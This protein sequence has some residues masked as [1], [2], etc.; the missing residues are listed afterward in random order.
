MALRLLHIIFAIAVSAGIYSTDAHIITP[1][2]CQPAGSRPDRVAAEDTDACGYVR[3]V[4]VGT[5]CLLRGLLVSNINAEYDFAPNWT[6]NIEGRYSALNYFTEL[7]KFRTLAF[8]AEMRYWPARRGCNDIR[9]GFYAEAHLGLGWFN[10]ALNGSTRYQ[11]HNGSSPTFGG[12]IGCGY[13]LPLGAGRRWAIDFSAGAGVY[14]LHY[15][16]FENASHIDDGPIKTERCRA[17]VLIDN[18]AVSISYTFDACR[19]K[20]GRP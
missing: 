15:D 6:A 13:R 2:D 10:I 20:G 9:Q 19:R 16:K 14:R 18:I 8:R 1:P 5:N 11:D 7:T 12:G 3:R 17:A 4:T